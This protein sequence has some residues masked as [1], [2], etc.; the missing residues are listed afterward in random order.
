VRRF[1]AKRSGR[2]GFGWKRWSS[3]VVY[4]QWGLYDD[5]HV[6]YYVDAKARANSNGTITHT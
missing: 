4:R 5:Y 2:G 6:R 3:D 1:A